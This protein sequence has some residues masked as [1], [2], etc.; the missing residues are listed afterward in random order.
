VSKIEVRDITTSTSYI[1]KYE[2]YDQ[3][4]SA[5]S[6]LKLSLS[7]FFFSCV[8]LLMCGCGSPTTPSRESEVDIEVS[9]GTFIKIK[10]IDRTKDDR[11]PG[12]RG[13]A[14]SF[15]NAV[16]KGGEEYAQLEIPLGD[17]MVSWEGCGVPI[18]L[19]K[20]EGLLYMI[21]FDSETDRNSP[22]FK[23]YILNGKTFAEI[24]AK[25]YPKSIAIQ[26]FFYKNDSPNQLDATLELIPT[27]YAFSGTLTAT[28][29]KQL[30]SGKKFY[31]MDDLHLDAEDLLEFTKKYHPV[32]LTR[33]IPNRSPYPPRIDES[34]INSIKVGMTVEEI[35]S[36][37]GKGTGGKYQGG[38]LMYITTTGGLFDIWFFDPKTSSG[39]N[40][41][42]VKAILKKIGNRDWYFLAPDEL[43]WKNVSELY[44]NLKSDGNVE[45][46]LVKDLEEIRQ[47]SQMP[48]Q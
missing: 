15:V 48:P 13:L 21:T 25:K 31:E 5:P 10:R 18:S 47:K 6:M 3:K 24:E 16:L 30:I 33:I 9:P 1:E 36:R 46:Q 20:Y 27:S 45:T 39:T 38:N 19:M 35:Q 8:L 17:I 12:W 14:G 28:I 26:N 2:F 41:N 23:Y 34:W 44:P 42:N 32:R 22:Q 7:L 40:L 29:W 4:L 11:K 37:L 43:M